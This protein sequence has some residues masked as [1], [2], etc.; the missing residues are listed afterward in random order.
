MHRDTHAHTHLCMC[1]HIIPWK[2]K[3]GKGMG[4]GMGMVMA[5]GERSPWGAFRSKAAFKIFTQLP[6]NY[7][8]T[9]A[10]THVHTQIPTCI[11]H[12]AHYN[13][14]HRGG[15][16]FSGVFLRLTRGR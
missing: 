9:N 12:F 8:H 3:A 16:V 2:M 11:I 6:Q 5:G 1:V 4:M 15:G 10:H 7:V 13:G 14:K